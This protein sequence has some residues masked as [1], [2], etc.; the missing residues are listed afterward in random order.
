MFTLAHFSDPHLGPLPRMRWWQFISKRFIGYSNWRIRR[1]LR[2]NMTSLTAVMDDMKAQ[3]ADHIVCTGDLCVIGL[4]AEFIAGRA[5][6][7]GIGSPDQVSL[8]P[9]NHDTYVASTARHPLRHWRDYMTSDDAWYPGHQDSHKLHFPY[10]RRIGKIAL[11]GVS[12]AV[13]TGPFFATGRVGR[14]QN[15]RLAKA[16]EE[17]GAQGF[18]RVVLIH[19]PP[20][21]GQHRLRRLTDTHRVQ[22]TL[23]KY[24]AELVLH[25]H[26]H[27]SEQELL[28]RPHASSI[29]IVGVTSASAPAHDPKEAG[30]YNLYH[31]EE[32]PKGWRCHASTRSLQPDQSLKEI[33]SQEYFYFTHD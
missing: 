21:R 22:E 5:F 8:I 33:W 28:H 18:F 3:N 29:P 10:V 15:A 27:I 2:H 6:M 9:G 32:T 20:K 31:I 26:N 1:V 17:L 30:G 14:K 12:S 23:L 25:G 4:K 16:L 7:E 19:H 13:P 24:G 11:I